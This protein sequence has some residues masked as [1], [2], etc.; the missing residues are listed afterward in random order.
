MNRLICLMLV[1]ILSLSG[2]GVGIARSVDLPFNGFDISSVRWLSIEDWRQ[3][4]HPMAAW[5]KQRDG[6]WYSVTDGY[7]LDFPV[8]D[9]EVADI[10]GFLAAVIGL[11][12]I[13]PRLA[14]TPS[15]VATWSVDPAF[16][17]PD[18]CATLITSQRQFRN[19]CIFP[20]RDGTYWAMIADSSNHFN[21]WQL[22]NDTDLL[23]KLDA[24]HQ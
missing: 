14:Y 9:A 1:T 21:F 3:P 7:E 19:F 11:P 20:A 18:V 17:P 23:A 8:H 5:A 16:T 22:A 15:Q 6:V 13:G 12:V 2:I 4:G 10:N 24:F